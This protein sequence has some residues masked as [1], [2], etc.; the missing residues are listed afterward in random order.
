MI[1]A[2]L[3]VLF[4]MLIYFSA[5]M[6]IHQKVIHLGAEHKE[7]VHIGFALVVQLLVLL[8]LIGCIL[9]L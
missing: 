4:A 3:V 7:V 5:T 9:F 1:A 8:I 2:K 6:Y